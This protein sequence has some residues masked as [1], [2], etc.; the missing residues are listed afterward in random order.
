MLSAGGGQA[1]IARAAIFVAAV[2]VAAYVIRP[3]VAAPLAFDTAAAVL[4]FDRIASGHHLEAALSTTP[5]P[6][7]TLL[8]GVIYW[9]TGD[10]R[11]I[12][13]TTLGAWGLCVALGATLAWRLGGAV[14]AGFVVVLLILSSRLLLETAW[15]LGSVWAL[16]FWFIAG[17][18]VAGPRPRWG[19]AGTALGI[20]ALARL[21]TFLAIGLALAVLAVMRF[22]P[23][24]WRRPAP[25]GAWWISIA[26]LAV[27]IMCIHDVLLTGDPLYWTSVASGYSAAAASSGRLPDLVAVARALVALAREQGAVT[28]LTVLGGAVLAVRSRWALLVGVVS[29]GPG[30]AA[31]LLL[32]AARHIFV[33]DRYLV[34]IVVAMIFT[35]AIGLSAISI[36]ELAPS[37]SDPPRHRGGAPARWRQAIAAL[38]VAVI[39]VVSSPTIGPLDRP[40]RATIV[41]ARHLA[42]SAERALPA[43]RTA[44]ADRIPGGAASGGSE[45]GGPA[46][47]RR[48]V[49]PVPIRPRIAVD[50]GL[51]L[52]Q[53]RSYSDPRA[54]A[55]GGPSVGELILIVADAA[56]TPSPE[57]AA[58]RL[59]SPAT[60][61]GV[62]L[63]PL[64]ADP[65]EGVW[66][67]QVAGP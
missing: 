46:S 41:S 28:V 65:A 33:D 30:T 48:V 4:H 32:L 67:L 26:L 50:L 18:A 55:A 47:T 20:A 8:Y 63:V 22:G 64:V 45:P 23:R 11:A 54:W 6:L 19:I 40:T 62:P 59:S 15:A 43:I 2:A 1:Q 44:L 57:A 29:L 49:V 14:A 38:V 52:D 36:P 35:A 51:P 66:L 25:G 60:V 13:V 12:S 58:F 17:L 7:L 21:E 37:P 5:K 27:P 39:A 10:W 9:V 61:Q 3:W 34:P 16:L 42:Q 24:R 56:L 53:V 31:F